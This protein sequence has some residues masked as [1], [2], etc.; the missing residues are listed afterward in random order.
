M[1]GQPSAS[2]WQRRTVLK[3]AGLGMLAT[4]AT[5]DLPLL[6]ANR[7]TACRS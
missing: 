2:Q 3:G 5:T 7:Y 1:A 4:M 6:M